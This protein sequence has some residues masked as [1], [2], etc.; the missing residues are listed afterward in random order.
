MTKEEYF[1]LLD[2]DKPPFPHTEEQIEWFDE[3]YESRPEVKE[4]NEKALAEINKRQATEYMVFK[5]IS[6]V[7]FRENSD[8]NNKGNFRLKYND[9]QVSIYSELNPEAE[10]LTFNL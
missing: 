8:E 5:I 10:P 2:G 4:E 3:W 7:F 6:N 9:R 1:K